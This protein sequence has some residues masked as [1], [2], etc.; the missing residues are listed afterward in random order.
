MTAAPYTS[1]LDFRDTFREDL[2]LTGRVGRFRVY[3]LVD[4]RETL[5]RDPL[6]EC[7]R[8]VFRLF[9]FAYR[10]MSGIQWVPTFI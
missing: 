10:G 3:R 9:L 7:L 4:F 6:R 2:R 5:L 1:A 8:E